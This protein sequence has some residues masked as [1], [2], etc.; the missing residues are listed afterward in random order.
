MNRWIYGYFQKFVFLI[1][2]YWALFDSSD[3]KWI[4]F[5]LLL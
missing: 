1:L 5:F 2:D 4:I 3:D